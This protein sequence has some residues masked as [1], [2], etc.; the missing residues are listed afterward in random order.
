M[1]TIQ[2]HAITVGLSMHDVFISYESHSKNIADAI[3][4][5]LERN[6]IRCWYAPRDVGTGTYAASIIDAIKNSKV[7]VLV[8][9]QNASESPHVLNEVETAYKRIKDG[10]TIIPFKISDNVSEEMEYYVKRILWIDAMTESLE[11][12]IDKLKQYVEKLTG[13]GSQEK[14]KKGRIKNNYLERANEKEAERLSSQVCV[15][16]YLTAGVYDKLVQGKKDLCILDIGSNRGEQIM[17]A[18]GNRP[19]IK[20]I[21]GVDISREV[22]DDAKKTYAGTCANFYC[23]DCESETFGSMIK[24]VMV[25]NNIE[26]F[27]IIN[28]SSSLHNLKAPFKTLKV[29]RGV[30]AKNGAFMIID[31]DD[32]LFLAY[33]DPEGA[34]A[35]AIEIL[36]QPDTSGYR[37]SGREVHSLLK[38]VGMKDIVLEKNGLSTVGMSL[39]IKE[40]VYKMYIGL[41]P[42][43]I[44]ESINSDPENMK[45]RAD[46]EWIQD[47]MDHLNQVFF[48][49]EF[50]MNIGLMVYTAR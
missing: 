11:I 26:S 22:V 3:C 8:L 6:K 48:S 1:T 20:K 17:S 18:L 4:S 44:S 5:T 46:Q 10:L 39:E 9:N 14:G 28:M 33:P 31:V 2:I 42:M 30:L 41:V 25:E 27:D 50:L 40:H 43:V 37:A 32:G 7:F 16:N 19:E 29:A 38:K 23:I 35:R 36:G 21:I 34:F 15:I 49:E 47:K 45:Y 13:A 12:S 24:E